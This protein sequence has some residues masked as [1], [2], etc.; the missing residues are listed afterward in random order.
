M[1]PCYDEQYYEEIDVKGKQPSSDM[2]FYCYSIEF[3]HFVSTIKAASGK[4]SQFIVQEPYILGNFGVQILTKKMTPM[5][6]DSNII[7]FLMSTCEIFF[8]QT[9]HKY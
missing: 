7:L 9:Y 3:S 1:K 5:L 4:C 6:C 2:F 8:A